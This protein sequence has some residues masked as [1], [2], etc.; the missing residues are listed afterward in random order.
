MIPRFPS[1]ASFSFCCA[2]LLLAGSARNGIAAWPHAITGGV[3]VVTDPGSQALEVSVSDGTGGAIFAWRDLRTT[4]DVYAQRVDA[5]GHAK[6]PGG[7]AVC[8]A[9]GAQDQITMTPDGAGGARSGPRPPR[10]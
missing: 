5:Y 3:P 4:I 8:T 2:L 6:W 9:A 1:R 7:V 10:G